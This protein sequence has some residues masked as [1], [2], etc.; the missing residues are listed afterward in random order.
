MKKI[1]PL[2]IISLFVSSAI[3]ADDATQLVSQANNDTTVL[4]NDESTV[5]ITPNMQ[6][7]SRSQRSEDAK[8]GCTIDT[9]YPQIQGKLLSTGAKEF[10]ATIE[11]TVNDEINLFKS[12]VALDLP[13]QKTLPEDVEKIQ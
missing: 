13:H 7:A 2:I 6:I 1:I 10:N 12:S 8:L 4:T 3:F 11:R 5:S 9:K